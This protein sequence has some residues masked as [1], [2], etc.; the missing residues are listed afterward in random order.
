MS[1]N[2]ARPVTVVLVAAGHRSL[3]YAEYAK[4]HPD[5]MQV[6]GVVEPD[7]ELRR[8][9]ADRFSLPEHSVYESVEELTQRSG[10]IADAAINGTMD[11]LHVSTTLPLLAAGYDVLLEKPIGISIEEIHDLQ[12][13][14]HKYSRKVMICHVLRYA[15]FYMEIHKRVTAGTIGELLSI[16]TI[17]NVSYHHMAMGFLRGKWNNKEVCGSS[18]LLAKCCHDLDLLVWLKNG[19]PPIAVSSFGGLQY[20]RKEF[21]PAGSGER[22]YDCAIEAACDYSAKKHHVEMGAWKT[23]LDPNYRLGYVPTDEELAELLRTSSPYGRCVW[24]SD[25]NVVDHQTVIVE[26]ADGT[27]ASHNMTGGVSKPCRRIH[28][29]GTKGEI[30]GE[31]EHNSFVIRHPDPRR[32]HE[33]RE[34]RVELGNANTDSHGGGDLRLVGDFVRILKGEQPSASCTSL[35]TSVLSHEIGFAADR[36]MERRETVLLQ[37]RP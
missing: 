28:L 2:L 14:A 17:E 23:Y 6:T 13:A 32:G 9:A 30:E 3:I 16:Q 29:L 22:C 36:S 7:P 35:D 19:V 1:N 12:A 24:K 31:L 10:L 27:T 33:F 15:P 5:E 37:E 26:F 8:R 4:Q 20:F 21:A 25:N 18:M 34:E 11:K